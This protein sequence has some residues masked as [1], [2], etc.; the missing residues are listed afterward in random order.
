LFS[1][2]YI[3]QNPS[4][5]AGKYLVLAMDFSAVQEADIL[6]SFTEVVN[7]SISGFSQKYIDAGLLSEPIKIDGRR[8][9]SSISNLA[10]AVERSGQEL[11][12]IVD[13]VDSFTN[14]LLFQVSRENGLNESG[15]REFVN[16]GGLLLRDFGRVVKAETNTCISRMFLTG[17]LPVAWSDGFSSFNIMEDLTHTNAFQHTLGL[18]IGDIA[19][20][21]AQRFA[22]MP[23]DVQG[24]HL[25]AIKNTSSGFRRSP[26]QAEALYSPQGVWNYLEQLH[27]KGDQMVPRTEPSLLPSEADVVAFLVK[28]AAGEVAHT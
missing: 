1:G 16:K 4:S 8:F 5:E 6:G 24:Q 25:E 17:V 9:G 7:T 18:K 10:A 20:I 28:H 21:L 27:H 19:E 11:S 2:T 26:Y 3:G 12:L 13:E 15:Y 22:G 23:H 14:R